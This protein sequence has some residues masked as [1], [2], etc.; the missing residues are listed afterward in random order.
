MLFYI[1]FSLF[2]GINQNLDRQV[3]QRDL[4]RKSDP[5]EEACDEDKANQ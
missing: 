4:S 1:I 2:S 5:E 3:N